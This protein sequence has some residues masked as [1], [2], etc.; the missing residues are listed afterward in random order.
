MFSPRTKAFEPT[1][2]KPHWESLGPAPVTVATL[3]LSSFFCL[4]EYN[5]FFLISSYTLR[6][7]FCVK[8]RC[9]VA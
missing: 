6:E 8:N 2:G 1:P 3:L 5:F 9:I 7:A 4:A